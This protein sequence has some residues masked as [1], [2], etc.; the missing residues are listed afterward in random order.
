MLRRGLGCHSTISLTMDVFTQ[1][2]VEDLRGAI[3]NLPFRK[4]S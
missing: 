1:L 4:A 3:Y 2:D